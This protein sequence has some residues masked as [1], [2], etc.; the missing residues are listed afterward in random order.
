[1]G[2]K[3]YDRPQSISSNQA[4]II[5]EASKVASTYVSHFSTEIKFINGTRYYLKITD[6]AGMNVVIP[7]ASQNGAPLT[8]TLEISRFY[9]TSTSPAAE[10]LIVDPDGIHYEGL[11]SNNDSERALAEAIK[12]SL[13]GTE[14]NPE[15][16]WSSFGAGAQCTFIGIRYTLEATEFHRHKSRAL[17]IEELDYVVSMYDPHNNITREHPA[18]MQGNFLR[19]DLSNVVSFGFDVEIN[20]PNN[21]FGSRYIKV[22]ERVV[23]I[24]PTRNPGKKPGI[25][26]S[27][28]NDNL[29][30][31]S[32]DVTFYKFTDAL[33]LPFLYRYKEAAEVHGIDTGELK[34]SREHQKHKYDMESAIRAELLAQLKHE[35][36]QDILYEKRRGDRSSAAT[37]FFSEFPKWIVPLCT[38][39]TALGSLITVL[40]K[41]S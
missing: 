3:A 27:Y 21:E 5:S 32:H 40:K 24:S 7:P 16:Q 15:H 17:Y 4:K 36:E 41:K 2:N 14:G 38:A 23:E 9:D 34:S 31:D 28:R 26:I 22:A 1:M 25:Y 19:S 20:D 37:K 39:I 13:H 11:H 29:C 10:K 33:K 35:R 30:I 18:T 8:N 12:T 6:R